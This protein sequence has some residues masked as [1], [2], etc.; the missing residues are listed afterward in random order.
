VRKS[1]FIG[2]FF[3]LALAAAAG[4]DV[5]FEQEAKFGG[6]AK[7][8]TMGKPMKT[9]TYISADKMRTDSGRVVQILDLAAEKIY[10][11]DTKERTYTVMTFEEM[12]QKMKAA[13][14]VPLNLE[15]AAIPEIVAIACEVKPKIATLVPE[16]RAELTTEGGLD[17]VSYQTSIQKV[18]RQLKEAG[19]LVSLFID[20]DKG[21]I[22][23]SREIGAQAIEFHTGCFCDV[24]SEMQA[25]S[26]LTRLSQAVKM[27]QGTGLKICAGH[28]INYDNAGQI[29]AALTEVEEYNIGHSIVARSIFVGMEKAVREMKKLLEGS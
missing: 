14:T 3:P 7:I 4:A 24:T 25:S 28:G 1:L 22:E 27:C 23:A 16:R 29:A 9:V 6:L 8:M 18:V 21:Q 19:I 15:M 5:S 11:L 20:P 26:E 13:I 17:V 10:D 12:R 2:A